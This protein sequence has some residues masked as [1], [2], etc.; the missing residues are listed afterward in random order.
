MIL[1]YTSAALLKAGY[2]PQPLQRAA[3]DNFMAVGTHE[4]GHMEQ[5]AIYASNET[6]E[7]FWQVFCAAHR[8]LHRKEAA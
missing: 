2:N 4:R 3:N 5:G 6:T 7:R 1:P 8:A